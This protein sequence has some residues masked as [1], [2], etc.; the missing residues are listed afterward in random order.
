MKLPP[1]KVKNI[2]IPG[3]QETFV[4][5]MGSSTFDGATLRIELC[6]TRL[7][8]PK[9]P[10]PPT[11]KKYPVCRLVLPPDAAVE[12]FNLLQQFIGVMVQQG[13]V[14]KEDAPKGTIQ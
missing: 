3:L 14:K 10:K 12:L 2:D 8:L 5:S 13:L 9:P 7:D 6:V 4:D 11:G 1:D